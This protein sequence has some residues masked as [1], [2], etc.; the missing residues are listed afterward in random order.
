MGTQIFVAHDV[1]GPPGSPAT[2]VG[3]SVGGGAQLFV[4]SNGTIISTQVFAGG[5]DIVGGA[6]VSTAFIETPAVAISTTLT[7]ANL[8]GSVIFPTTVGATEFVSG[9]GSA[10]FTQVNANTAQIVENTFDSTHSAVASGT[11]VN[12]GGTEWVEEG[13]FSF[14]AT[15][16]GLASP[17]TPAN[18]FVAFSTGEGTTVS[19]VINHNA[20]EEVFG[21]FGSAIAT[22]VNSGGNQLINDGFA[23]GTIV[24]PGGGELVFNDGET[25]NTTLAGGAQVLGQTGFGFALSTTINS[26]GTQV[27]FNGEADSST[28]T[29]G[30]LV[31][32]GMGSGPTGPFAGDSDNAKVATGGFI[33]DVGPLAFD[34][35]STLN[36][37]G[38]FLIDNAN[39]DDTTINPGGVLTITGSG[40]GSSTEFDATINRGGIE[41]LNSG[42]FDGF[43]TVRGTQ[44]VE[45]GGHADSAD[46]LAGGIQSVLA[47]GLETN[48]LIDG[49][50]VEL[51]SGALAG[52]PATPINFSTD[53]AGGT[54]ALDFSQGFTGAIAGFASPSGVSE[55]IDLKDIAFGPNTTR[56]F[57][58]AGGNTSGT[59]SVSDGTHTANLTLLGLYSTAN[60]TLSSD[61]GG[62][63]F[64]RD[65]AVVAS[66]TTLAPHA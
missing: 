65:P 42:S 28:V 15:A 39:A 60:F 30:T 50:L 11:T 34:G 41:V 23:V 19:S 54:L 38:E 58:E 5:A 4:T 16:T 20:I 59:L 12:F 64:V 36:G 6:T 62:G 46:V 10:F 66:A 17:I 57:L 9:G 63:T 8:P 31:D 45:A 56:S 1:N 13:G 52:G 35:G 61:G 55:Q 48:T 21:G 27:V 32:W 24:N 49:G 25:S 53:N 47:G 51:T 29:N 2:E 33:F 44:F 40:T 37:G 18:I 22:T 43:A 14:G 3:D 7:A 26:G